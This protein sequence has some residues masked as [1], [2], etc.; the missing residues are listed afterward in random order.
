MSLIFSKYIDLPR[1][2]SGGFDHGD[3]DSASGKIFVAHT[4]NHSIDIIDGEK[5][6]YSG[7]ISGCPGASGVLCAQEEAL[8]FAAARAAGKVLVISSK[9]DTKLREILVGP[10]PNG[11]AWDSLRKLLFVADVEDY[12]ARL[13]SPLD[14]STLFK[15]KL[16]GR[17]RW[18]VYDTKGDR[19]LVNIMDPSGVAT[20]DAKSLE[21]EEF[22]PISVTGPHGLDVDQ[23]TDRAFVA[24]DGKAV[25]SLNLKTMREE[26]QTQIAGAPDVM[27]H[28][29]KSHQLYCAIADPGVVDIIDTESMTVISE[30]PTE[31]GAHTLTFD[32]ARQRLYVFMPKRCQAAVYEVEGF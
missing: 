16:P 7:S 22:I 17:P 12:Y 19:F 13:I 18:C 3:V 4:A 20:L 28:N 5:L 2:D 11:L 6:A 15:A 29:R 14:G 26:Q 9:S 32:N 27:W 24:C 8:T 10:K 31:F 25:A 21:R 1:H 23:N 30:I